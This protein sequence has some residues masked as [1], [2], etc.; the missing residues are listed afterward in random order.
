MEI[1]IYDIQD[2]NDLYSELKR[3]QLPYNVKVDSIFQKRTNEQNRYYYGIVVKVLAEEIGYYAF[4]MHQLLLRMFAK[5]GEDEDEYGHKYDITESTSGM[6][7]MRMEK[8]MNDIKVFF[9]TEF[10]ILVPDI[11]EKDPEEIYTEKF[12]FK[13]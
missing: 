7:T 1:K 5:I 2:K 8:Y 9:L 12:I 11:G 3:R 10:K 6:D 4:E 13:P